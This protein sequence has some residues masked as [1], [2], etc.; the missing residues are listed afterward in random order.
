MY[1]V[2]FI[3]V[4]YLVFCCYGVVFFL[5]GVGGLVFE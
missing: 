5:V 4:G 3:A 2:Y 1:R